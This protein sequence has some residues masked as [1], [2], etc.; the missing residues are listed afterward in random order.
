MTDETPAPAPEKPKRTRAAA[1]AATPAPFST[2]AMTLPAME[3]PQA[4]REMTEKSLAYARDNYE[5]MKTA[6][7][8]ATDVLED[9]YENSRR[10]VIELQM[11][12]LDAA[13]SNTD[14]TFSFIREFLSAK[15]LSE[16]IELQ[17]AFTRKQFETAVAQSKEF[18]ELATKLASESGAPMKDAFSKVVKDFKA[19]A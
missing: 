4:V 6:A 16:A 17:T 11:K 15:S 13:K 8:E 1:A 5:K 9:T 2:E 14:S 7:E 10:G 19:A 12:V 3:M 18:Q